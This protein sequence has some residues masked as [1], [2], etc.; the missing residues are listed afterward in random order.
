MV[1]SA[2]A[3]SS[4]PAWARST[5][6]HKDLG[7]RFPGLRP[8]HHLL[9][10]PFQTR[11]RFPGIPSHT[12]LSEQTRHLTRAEVSCLGLGKHLVESYGNGDSSADGHGRQVCADCSWRRSLDMTAEAARTVFRWCG[13]PSFFRAS[14]QSYVSAR[15]QQSS[16]TVPRNRQMQTAPASKPTWP[17]HG[18]ED[19]VPVAVP[20]ASLARLPRVVRKT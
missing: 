9:F 7:D 6:V 4:R 16:P 14:G 3:R 17:R 2:E 19:V 12:R 20:P 18:R 5:G 1:T 15:L 11:A 8:A 13:E 10:E